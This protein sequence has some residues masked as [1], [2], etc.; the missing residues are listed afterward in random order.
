MLIKVF[1]EVH[2]VL[3][4]RKEREA[5]EEARAA[6]R[7]EVESLL[8][9]AEHTAGEGIPPAA[10]RRRKLLYNAKEAAEQLGGISIRT[11]Y[12][13]MRAGE[14]ESVTIG[15]RRMFPGEALEAYVEKLRAK[16]A[17]VLPTEREIAMAKVGQRV[18]R[19]RQRR[20]PTRE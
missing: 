12:S 6:V 4:E 1:D 7:A 3:W 5:F 9:L 11:L 14:I 10:E 13:L 17:E 20:R 2:R 8:Q 16:A 15:S 18:M 19:Q